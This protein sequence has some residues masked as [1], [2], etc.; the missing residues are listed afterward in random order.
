MMTTPELRY[1]VDLRFAP[2]SREEHGPTG[3][4]C[5]RGPIHAARRILRS[6]PEFRGRK[7]VA[8]HVDPCPS[9]YFGTDR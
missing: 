4:C 9:P 5:A 1:H 6:F 8:I 2:S 7:I 3:S